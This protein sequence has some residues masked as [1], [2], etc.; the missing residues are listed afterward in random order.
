MKFRIGDMVQCLKD[1]TA[2]LAVKGKRLEVLFPDSI[3]GRRI[4]RVLDEDGCEHFV[5]DSLLELIPK[6][7]VE[8]PVVFHEPAEKKPNSAAG[9]F[10]TYSDSF[11]YLYPCNSSRELGWFR[12]DDGLH[13][14]AFINDMRLKEE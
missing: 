14:I 9:S 8:K 5:P 1:T 3:Y 7:K 11:I 12:T 10:Y 4:V 2:P 6:E 13:F